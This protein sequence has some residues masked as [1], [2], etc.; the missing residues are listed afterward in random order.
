MLQTTYQPETNHMKLITTSILSLLLA[1]APSFA[2]GD[3]APV[4]PAAPTVSPTQLLC[5]TGEVVKT[6]KKKGKKTVKKC[7]KA[8]AGIIPNDEM[9]QQG[10]LLAKQG[11]YEWAL[12][13]LAAVT[14]QNNPNV[15][16]YMGYANR[17]AGRLD[18][19]LTYYQ[20]AL[21]INPDFVLAREYLGEGYVAAGKLDLAK[22]QLDEIGKRGGV[23]SEEYLD[24]SK[25]I[26]GASI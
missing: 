4:A 24:L 7:M 6:I 21:T 13:V 20:K 9:Y 22:V 19:A 17:K 15:L 16:N 1:T 14:D 11:E 18:I 12:T 25:A 8:T 2:A 3:P 23:T 26:K 5:K 10:R